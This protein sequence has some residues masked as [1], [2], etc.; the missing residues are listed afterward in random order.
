MPDF[1]ESCA[2]KY[3]KF[4]AG[5]DSGKTPRYVQRQCAE[6]LNI[7]DS[8]ETAYFDEDVFQK[9]GKLLRLMIH[10]DLNCPMLEGPEDY[11]LLFIAALFCT[12][13]R[14]ELR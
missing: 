1:R 11:A 13:T 14:I 4:A 5:D 12:K 10:P 6:W 9:I 2:Y 7:I 8:G 3:A